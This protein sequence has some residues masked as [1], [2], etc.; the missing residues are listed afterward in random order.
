MKCVGNYINWINPE[1]FNYMENNLGYSHPRLDPTEYGSRNQDTLEKVR[2]FGKESLWHNFKPSNFPFDI[3]LPIETTG[4]VDWW[5]VKMLT[6]D[7]IPFHSDH[8][9]RDGCEGKKARRFWMPLQD[10]V[11]GH[12]FLICNEFVKDYIA[13]DLFEYDP[14]GRH[15]GF[16]INLDVPRYTFNFAIY[17]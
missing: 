1:W 14:D 15:G 16:N 13:G 10:Y 8:A 2:R 9:P 6:G 3:T 5:F 11:E 7:L 12:V 17:E 4:R